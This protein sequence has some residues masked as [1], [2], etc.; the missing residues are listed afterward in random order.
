MHTDDKPSLSSTAK[1]PGPVVTQLDDKDVSTFATGRPLLDEPDYSVC[2]YCKKAIIKEIATAHVKQCLK[3]K[4][5]RT[6]ERKKAKE[7]KAA[8]MAA[9]LNKEAPVNGEVNGDSVTTEKKGAKKMAKKDSDGKSK[10]RKAD[11]MSFF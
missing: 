2:K 1:S 3:M 11:G 6:K 4:S 9:A 5:E 8:A 10:K 7:E